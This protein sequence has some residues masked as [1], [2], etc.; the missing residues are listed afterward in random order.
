MKQDVTPTTRWLAT[1]ADF[2][3]ALDGHAGVAERLLLLE[4]GH[5]LRDQ[6]LSYCSLNQVDSVNT[7]G[8]SS[9]S[10]IVEMVAAGY[11][12]TLLPEICLPIEQRG[13]SLDLVRFVEPQPFRRIGLA[14]RNTSPRE[15]DYTELGRLLKQARPKV[16]LNVREPAVDAAKPQRGKKRQTEKS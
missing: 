7:F 6:A 10:T 4:E 13:R 15:S 3:P 12:I 8:A 1:T 9:L 16:S 11:G 14:W 5:C 2:M